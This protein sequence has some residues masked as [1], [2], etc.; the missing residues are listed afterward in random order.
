MVG[1][2]CRQHSA[3]LHLTLRYSLC[4]CY[5]RSHLTLLLPAGVSSSPRPVWGEGVTCSRDVV[6]YEEP[7]WLPLPR[8]YTTS[9]ICENQL[10]T[11]PGLFSTE[12]RRTSSTKTG[13]P[14][15]CEMDPE[16]SSEA[17]LGASH[18]GSSS[19]IRSIKAAMIWSLRWSSSARAWITA[20]R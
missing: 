13:A 16:G 10:I 20:L 9:I 7:R 17:V 8:G 6:S 12:G 15:P 19:G 14:R 11:P 18:G 3:G 4:C 2:A 5:T 1:G